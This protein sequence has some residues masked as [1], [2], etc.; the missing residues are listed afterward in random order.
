[1]QGHFAS[2]A[3]AAG[4]VFDASA[5]KAVPIE[6]GYKDTAGYFSLYFNKPGWWFARLVMDA[7]K[8]WVGLNVP[9]E[10]IAPLLPPQLE[11]LPAH[12]FAVTRIA[13]DGPDDLL[14]LGPVLLAAMQHAVDARRPKEEAEV[15]AH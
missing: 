7:R 15:R 5:R 8:P 6:L 2:S 14:A 3:L 1:M 13:V 10:V 11:L 4:T 9:A 12:P